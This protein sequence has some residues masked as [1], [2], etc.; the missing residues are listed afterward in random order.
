MNIFSVNN[1][2]RKALKQAQQS[3][4]INKIISNFQSGHGFVKQSAAG[5]QTDD[6]TD[7][8]M[9]NQSLSLT[10]DGD[11]ASVFT[12]DS[13]LGGIDT[14]GKQLQLS[15]KVTNIANLGD[16][17]IWLFTDGGTG[18]AFSRRVMTINPTRPLLIEDDWG[19]VTLDIDTFTQIGS[20]SRDNITGFQVRINDDATGVPVTL[21]INSVSLIEKKST[22]GV[23]S[24][25][26]DDGWLS[27]Y[28]EA[29]PIMDQ[30][31]FPA[32]AYIIQD[33]IGNST[34]FMTMEQLKR[35]NDVNRWE[36]AA[37][38]YTMSAHEAKY[39]NLTETEID[40]EFSNLK[41]WLDENG[42]SPDHFAYP[43]GAY[44]A[45]VI[46]YIKKYFK[47]ARTVSETNQETFPVA[48]KYRMRIFN[49]VNT[50]SLDY[51]KEQVDRCIEGNTWLILC[52]HQFTDTAD[53]S[54]EVT[55][56]DF[57]TQMDY[58]AEVGVPVRTIK[59]VYNH[60]MI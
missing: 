20:P 2:A 28:S 60:G 34:N 1:R 31:G 3:N 30:Y 53:E 35:L 50:V 58:L 47:T 43:G 18:D 23:V 40:T 27:Q 21:K 36:I 49:V 22:Q 6:T 14:R 55:P 52:Y 41:Q 48:S 16:M 8:V 25:T 19:N 44:N 12:R 38:A 54:T 57:Q 26:M 51:F 59:D 32:T 15:F 7:Y 42:F 45:S 56:A 37:H 17:L 11:G 39:I 24:I 5:T 4:T 33:I 13:S 10:T 46:K 29:R 9:G